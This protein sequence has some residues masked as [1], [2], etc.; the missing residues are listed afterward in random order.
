VHGGQVQLDHGWRSSQSAA[1]VPAPCC[2]LDTAGSGIHSD[3][4]GR[5][6]VVD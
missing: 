2:C 1:G 4:T 3:L 6:D 5:G